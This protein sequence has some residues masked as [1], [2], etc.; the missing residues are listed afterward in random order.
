MRRLKNA[1]L[2]TAL[3]LTFTFTNIAT[4]FAFIEPPIDETPW[5]EPEPEMRMLDM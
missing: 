4:V 2:V 3:V 5:P 1:L